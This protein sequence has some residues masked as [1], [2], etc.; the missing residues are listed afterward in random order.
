MES[1]RKLFLRKKDRPPRSRQRAVLFLIWSD[2]EIEILSGHRNGC[3]FLYIVP[4]K[5]LN[6]FEQLLYAVCGDGSALAVLEI[7]LVLQLVGFL[8]IGF[9]LVLEHFV[10]EFFGALTGLFKLCE[11]GYLSVLANVYAERY[12]FV[13]ATGLL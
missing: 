7:V 11:I 6:L 10:N 5:V 4:V 12:D 9:L 8:G 13:F 3:L 1:G 2:G